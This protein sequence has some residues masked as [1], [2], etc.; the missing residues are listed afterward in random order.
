MPAVARRRLGTVRSVEGSPDPGR[1]TE[2]EVDCITLSAGTLRIEVLTYGAHLVG[3]WAPD[4]DGRIDNLVASQRDAAGAV[5]LRRYEDP[6]TNPHL[7]A[8]VGRYANR[9]G[10]STFDLDGA[11]IELDANEGPN[12]LHGGP[13]GFDRHVWT[14][15]TSSDDR[16]AQVTLRHVSPDGDQ[17]FP[18]TVEVGVTYR[19]TTDDDVQIDMVGRTDAPT[20]LNTTNHSYWNLGGT[21]DPSTCHVGGHEVSIAADRLVVVDRAMIPTGELRTVNDSVFELRRPTTVDHLLVHPDLAPTG[22][23]DHCLV[24]SPEGAEGTAELFDPRS[25]RRMRLRTDQPGVQ[26]YTSNHGAGSLPAHSTI[27]LETQALP[28]SPNQP[29]FPSAELRPGDLYR[30]RHHLRFTVDAV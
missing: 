4:R 10:G 5:D 14:A 20:V 24:F 19:V 22:G 23:M 21:S 8:I 17:G 7:G 11:Q 6:V 13:V 16:S 12:Q 15:T 3:V 27:C 28:D 29:R 30:H 25:G 9:I 26:V 2:V 18:G 1:G